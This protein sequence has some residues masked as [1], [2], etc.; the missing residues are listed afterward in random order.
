MRHRPL[1]AGAVVLALAVSLAACGDDGDED[2]ADT[3]TTEAAASEDTSTTEAAPDDTADDETTTTEAGTEDTTAEEAPDGDLTGLLLT[4]EDLGEGFV[5]QG[6]ETSTEA[7]PCGSMI[8]EE[9]PFDAI[10]GTVLVEEEL[11]LGLQHELRTYAD[12]DTAAATFAAAQ[13]A[14]SCGADTTQ[15]G[16]VLGEV[17]DVSADVGAEA[18]VVAVTS[19]ED[20]IEGGLVTVQVANVLSVYQFQGPTGVEEGPD[21]LTVVTANVEALQAELG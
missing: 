16:V 7:G 13:E 21:A 4:P 12:E 2:T 20:G 3:T 8:D 17:T 5:E 9:N 6:Y 15:P 11:G 18:F 19:E 14:L 10:V 1:L